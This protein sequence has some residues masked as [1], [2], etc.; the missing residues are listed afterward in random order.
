M[1]NEEYPEESNSDRIGDLTELSYD[2]RDRS[3]DKVKQMDKT[4]ICWKCGNLLTYNSQDIRPNVW[5]ECPDD[6]I[7]ATRNPNLDIKKQK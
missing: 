4:I 3:K 6:L 5:H 1:V 2:L 7:A